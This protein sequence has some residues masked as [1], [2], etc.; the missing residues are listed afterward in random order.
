M[1]RVTLLI[2][3]EYANLLSITALGHTAV[4]TSVMTNVTTLVALIDNN[5]TIEVPVKKF[6]DKTAGDYICES[7]EIS[8]DN[9]KEREV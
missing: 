4:G 8:T 6:N 2:D 1:K 9:E 7:S 3:D 5:D